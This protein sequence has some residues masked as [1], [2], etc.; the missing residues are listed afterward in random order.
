MTRRD[1]DAAIKERGRRERY[2]QSFYVDRPVTD[3]PCAVEGNA[4]IEQFVLALEGY[5]FALEWD[6]RA[7]EAQR[8][9]RWWG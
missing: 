8:M 6:R 7:T 3:E 5:A 2:R 1:I 9:L 4:T